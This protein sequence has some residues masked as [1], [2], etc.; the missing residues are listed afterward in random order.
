MR[1][2]KENEFWAG[3][4][5]KSKGWGEV[6][7]IFS[8]SSMLWTFEL[9]DFG[10][11][12]HPKSFCGMAEQGRDWIE[13]PH[14][15]CWVWNPQTPRTQ[16]PTTKYLWE[17]ARGGLRMTRSRVEL[18]FVLLGERGILGEHPGACSPV[19]VKRPQLSMSSSAA[20]KWF[21]FFSLLCFLSRWENLSDSKWGFKSVFL[22][23]ILIYH[24]IYSMYSGRNSY[25]IKSKMTLGKTKEL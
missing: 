10:V 21:F 9:N 14:P 18:R 24:Y 1:I 16:L 8:I 13:P 22:N 2:C 11:L 23:E 15:S 20:L 19:Q 5:G 3:L 6:L 12:L 4:W 25:L 17:G 7:S